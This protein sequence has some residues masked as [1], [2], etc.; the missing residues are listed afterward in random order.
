MESN[1]RV[2]EAA[3]ALVESNQ[4]MQ[5]TMLRMQKQQAEFAADLAEQKKQLEATCEEISRDVSNQLYTFGQMRD[6]YEK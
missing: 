5:E 1:R 3:K 2:L 4:A 6:L